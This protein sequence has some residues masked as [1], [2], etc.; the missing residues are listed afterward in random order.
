M[1]I[2]ALHASHEQIGPRQLLADVVQ[3]ERAGFQAAMCSDHFALWGTRQGHS[4]F[5]WSR[6]GAVL[7]ATSLRKGVVT[8]PGREFD[9]LSR[10][11][12]EEGGRP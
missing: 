10:L 12:A 5:A 11:T 3:A 4:G 7:R 9:G 1:T 8:A 2:L 6:L